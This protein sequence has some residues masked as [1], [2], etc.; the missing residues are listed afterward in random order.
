MRM[1]QSLRLLCLV[2]ILNASTCLAQTTTSSS[3][4]LQI[5]VKAVQGGAQYRPAGEP[6]WKPLHIGDQLTEGVEFRTGPKGAIQF[7]VGTDQIF[8][9]DRLTV[10]KVLRASLRTDGTIATDVGLQYGRVSKDVDAPERPHDDTIVSP[11]STLAVRGTRVSLW[12]QPPYTPEAVSLT[13]HALF[14]TIGRQVVAF[15]AKGEGTAIVNADQPDPADNSLN[16]HLVDPA[17]AYARTPD[18][19]KLLADLI[20]NGAVVVINNPDTLPIVKDATPP[21]DPLVA[22][23][24]DVALEFVVRWSANTNIN[25]EMTVNGPAT[26]HEF[27][28][29]ALGLNSTPLGG[30]IL[31][32]DQGGPTGG[33]EIITYPNFTFLHGLYGL[34]AVNVGPLASTATFNA[35]LESNGVQKPLGLTQFPT[36]NGSSSGVF[37]SVG[38]NIL[39][40]N[41]GSFPNPPPTATPQPLIQRP[42]IQAQSDST[43]RASRSVDLIG[44]R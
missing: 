31:F 14:D 7:T 34:D 33:Y 37:V 10:V 24:G 39:F 13:G 36:P 29:P 19:E 8:R 22:P 38:T 40:R 30:H 15:G 11:S 3:S 43:P 16:T 12:D 2:L 23:V 26:T 41:G 42:A 32:D 18:E 6:R 4:Q 28:Y 17:D 9:V 35:F 1:T 44:V 5:L 20:T 21:P 25:L 27:I